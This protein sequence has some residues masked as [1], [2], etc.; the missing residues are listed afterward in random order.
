M[1]WFWSSWPQIDSLARALGPGGLAAAWLAILAGSTVIL[2]G[3]EACHRALL[4]VQWRGTPVVYSHYTRTAWN[5]ALFVV[6]VTTIILLDS[7]APDIV[8]KTF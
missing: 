4:G 1:F 8:Y 7:P 6:A 3:V 2:A 5:T